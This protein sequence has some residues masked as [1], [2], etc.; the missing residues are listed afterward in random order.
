MASENAFEVASDA[1]QLHGAYGCSPMSSVQR[2]L[3]DAKIQCVIEGTSQ[4][5]EIQTSQLTLTSW[6]AARRRGT[7]ATSTDE[8]E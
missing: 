5:Q 7:P 1:V 2:H 8:R 6:Q 3:R 4:I